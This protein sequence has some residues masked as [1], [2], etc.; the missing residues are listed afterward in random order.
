MLELT[1]QQWAALCAVDERNFVATVRD[2][3]VQ[4]NPTLGSDPTLLDRLVRAYD[5]ARALGL[6]QDKLLVDFLYVEVEVPGFYRKPAVENWLSKPVGTA[7][8]RFEDL[9][10]VLRRK[11]EEREENC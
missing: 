2:D 8:T 9:L 11:L 10:A 6:R 7:D 1:E 5:A 3:I 4:A